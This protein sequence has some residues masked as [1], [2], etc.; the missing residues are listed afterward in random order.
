MTRHIDIQHTICIPFGYE[1][2]K[3]E[4]KR[5]SYSNVYYL[6]D[7]KLIYNVLCQDGVSTIAEILE[8]CQL[9]K[10]ESIN[11]KS[12]TLRNILEIVNALKNFHLI[13]SSNN[14]PYNCKLFSYNRELTQQDYNVFKDIY[15]NYFRFQE[16]H[17]LFIGNRDLSI[18][19]L[20]SDSQPIYSFSR[21]SR[22][23]N[24]FLINKDTLVEIDQKKTEIMR[25]WDVYVKWGEVL[26]ILKKYPLKAFGI[27]LTLPVKFPSIVY[28]V[29]SMPQEFSIFNF[30]DN[31]FSSDYLYIPD[32]IEC[33]IRKKRFS[34][35][36]IK[37]KLYE[38]CVY[39]SNHYRPQSTSAI[40]I[41]K[42]EEILFLK[43]GN[44]YMTHLLKLK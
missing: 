42:H 29:R 37:T 28:F 18:E 33:I 13:S 31:E 9:D 22:F 19:M 26:G 12:W 25:F 6:E 10:L 21:G 14:K 27:Q 15:F 32:I 2:E 3:S 1:P 17:K 41:N 4:G 30:I 38:E 39:D 43:I 20:L 35:E 16:F 11:G 40:F 44:M 23:T 7:L 36:Q 34:L 8:K 24:N 5:W